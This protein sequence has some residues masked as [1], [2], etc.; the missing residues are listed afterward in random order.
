MIIIA[1]CDSETKNALD[2]LIAS[3]RYGDLAHTLSTAIQTLEM[4]D[5]A[6][7][8]GAVI[9]GDGT[10]FAE[11]IEALADIAAATPSPVTGAATVKRSGSRAKTGRTL[12]CEPSPP[13]IPLI[14]GLEGLRALLVSN[15]PSAPPTFGLLTS[16]SQSTAG[17]S[18]IQQAPAC[19]SK[20]QSLGQVR[21]RRQWL[22]RSQNRSSQTVR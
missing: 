16:K 21:S 3:R 1:S 20:R 14:F 6:V 9:L 15:L 4:L 19:Q 10:G 18:A 7:Q 11:Q 2:R 13:G 12:S 8:D 17:S 22:R 5:R